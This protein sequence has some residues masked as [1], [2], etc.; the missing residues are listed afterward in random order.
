M[1]MSAVA[2]T[3]G[4]ALMSCGS[5]KLQPTVSAT[6]TSAPSRG[7]EA[8]VPPAPPNATAIA[9]FLATPNNAVL[10]FERETSPLGT[11]KVPSREMCQDI[12]HIVE[13]AGSPSAVNSS[14]MGIANTAIQVAVNQ[15]VQA[16]LELLSACSEG[17]STKAE[18]SKVSNTQS[19]VEKEF[20]QIGVSLAGSS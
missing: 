19:V 3:C 1:I 14:I 20:A 16:K 9:T 2:A 12:A 8:F 11:G 7:T 13:S 6:S 18:T 10:T 5:P 15:D 4:L 17:T